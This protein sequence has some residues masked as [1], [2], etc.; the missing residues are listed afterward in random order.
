MCYNTR[1]PEDQKRLDRLRRKQIEAIAADGMYGFSAD[2]N[3][4]DGRCSPHVFN[5]YRVGL[6]GAKGST[7]TD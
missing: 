4:S 2:G 7:E 5:V 1:A 6:N 3:G